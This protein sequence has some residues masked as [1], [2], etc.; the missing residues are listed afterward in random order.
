MICKRLSILVF[1]VSLW[2]YVYAQYE[3]NTALRVDELVRKIFIGTPE[4]QVSNIRLKGSRNGLAYFRF[5]GGGKLGIQE[6]I[7]LTTGTA[8]GSY[9]PNSSPINSNDNL[10][11]GDPDLDLLAKSTTYDAAVLEFDFIPVS[12]WIS[13]RY[14]FASEE[15]LEYV[16]RGFNDVFGFF[17]MGPGIE[18]PINL[19][20]VP[21]TKDVVSVNTINTTRNSNFYLDNGSTTDA[22]VIKGVN[23][24]SI[25]EPA[26]EWD[27]FTRVLTVRYRVEPHQTYHIK[28]AIADVGD[29]LVDSGVYL[30]GKSFKAEGRII[31]PPPK[32]MVNQQNKTTPKRKPLPKELI[33]EFDFDSWRVPDT[34][35]EKMYVLWN[36]LRE[37]PHAKF[38]IYGHTDNF[39]SNSY[40]KILAERRVRTVVQLLTRYGC[41]RSR[42]IVRESFG[43][44][45][46]KSTNENIFGRAR[47]RRVEIV[48]RWPKPG[49]ADFKGYQK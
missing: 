8:I 35:K 45:K 3:T 16:N 41:P 5:P 34:S 42:I 18:K 47:N 10:S 49:E 2:P 36:I 9:G 20:V 29:R 11:P 22:K 39:G 40:N 14:V 32:D 38:Q 27:G 31:W 23:K 30:E 24:A 1:F 26:L 12:D 28:L 19:A 15:Y 25:I 48:I 37:Y 7:L 33:V 6:G 17:L 43:E 44:D 4:I 21:G 13:F 46:P